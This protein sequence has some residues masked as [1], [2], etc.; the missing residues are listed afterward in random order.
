MAA[1]TTVISML[2]TGDEVICVD[3]VYGGS[4]RLFIKVAAPRWGLKVKI[5]SMEDPGGEMRKNLSPQTKMLWIESPTNPFLK[6][7]DI[8][9]CVDVVKKYN[10][11]ILIVVD[12]TFASP[13][14]QNPLDFGADLVLHSV[15]KYIGGHSDVLMGA[16]VT[17]DERLGQELAFLQ[18]AMGAVPSPFDC[19]LA[20]RG[21]KTLEVRMQRQC[22]NAA[23]IAAFLSKHPRVSKVY[24]PGLPSHP[25][26]LVAKAQ[27][28]R[29]GAMI[30]FELKAFDGLADKEILKTTVKLVQSCKVFTLAESLGGVESLI[31]VPSVMTHAGRANMPDSLIRLS[32]GIESVND[33]IADLENALKLAYLPGFNDI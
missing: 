30:S 1:M 25:G 6:I 17:N 10:K 12:N 20:M 7:V 31:E 26:H 24:Y 8:R 33:L 15:T 4:E 14:L 29:F 11:E 2:K 3:D 21:M 19:F 18:K 22:E 16:V 5:C 27:M 32:I 9:A 23:Q 13:V 28:R